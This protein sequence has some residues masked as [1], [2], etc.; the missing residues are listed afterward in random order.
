VSADGVLPHIH[1]TS[2]GQDL[3]K[4]PAAVA[5]MGGGQEPIGRWKDLALV[6]SKVSKVIKVAALHLLLHYQGIFTNKV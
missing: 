6:L 1:V 4:P 3:Q 2:T 5:H